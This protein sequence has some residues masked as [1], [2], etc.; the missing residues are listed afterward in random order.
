MRAITRATSLL[1]ISWALAAAAEA[2]A[3]DVFLTIGGGYSPAGN[4]VS[5]EKNIL[6]F[7][8]LLAEQR[9]DGASHDIYFADGH[10]P[11]RDLQFSNIEAVPMANWLM[12]ELFGEQEH[13]HLEYRNHEVPG[14]RGRTSE[15]N[16]EAWFE[17][18]GST[19][20][21]G[22]RLILYVTAHG[23]KSRDKDRPHN[24]RL[25]LWDDE[26]VPVSDLA[27]MIEGL[28]QGVQVVTVMVQCY[29]G[30]FASLIFN[31]G[32]EKAGLSDRDCCGFFATV[33]DRPAAGCTA[34]IHEDNY[35]EYSSYFW[36]ALGGFTRTGD[37]LERPDFNGDGEVSFAEA[38]AYVMLASSTIDIPVK[39]S[40]AFLRAH[41]QLGSTRRPELLSAD[42]R[43]EHLLRL[44]TPGEAAVLEGL[45]VELKLTSSRRADAADDLADELEEKRKELAEEVS[46]KQRRRRGLKRRIAADLRNRWPELENLLSATATSLL[47]TRAAEFEEAVLSHERYSDF[48]QLGE[49]IAALEAQ[50]FELERQWVK[51]R[52]LERVLENVALARNLPL[53]AS[54]D[55]VRRYERLMAAEESTLHQSRSVAPLPPEP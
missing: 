8:H 35:H 53:V 3:K 42:S 26:S 29:A 9:P 44:A 23:G 18:T 12:A 22:D 20:E 7:Q 36:A 19:L 40:G 51:C 34:D 17:E 43:F 25:Y 37:P 24:T 39:T 13:I 31:G 10:A 21:A 4:Q 54:P 49:E 45:S 46:R 48:S 47:T 14:V 11:D 50:R 1:L 27:Q 55:V 6:F 5:L 15:E 30:G 33:H 16:L 38:H 41:S 32:D 52:R 2:P 28:P